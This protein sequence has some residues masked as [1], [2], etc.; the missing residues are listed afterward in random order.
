M[1]QFFPTYALGFEVL[2]N[3]VKSQAAQMSIAP[4]ESVGGAD[5][6]HSAD[7]WM[8]VVDG[9]ARARVDT[10]EIELSAGTLLLIEAGEPHSI[11][12]ISDHPLKTLNFYAPPEYNPPRH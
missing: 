5:N 4:G 12:C 8:Y 2:G 7:Q 9:V 10:H 6:T 1:R 11:T 3:T